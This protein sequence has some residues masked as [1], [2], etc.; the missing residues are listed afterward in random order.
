M[1]LVAPVSE[2]RTL[3]NAYRAA[4]IRGDGEG[5]MEASGRLTLLARG[6]LDGTGG[7]FLY[8]SDGSAVWYGDDGRVSV[9][10][11]AGQYAWL[12]G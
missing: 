1:R 3:R 4:Q 2:A 8:Y 6:M 7:M 5:V 10:G 11:S 12:V 9:V